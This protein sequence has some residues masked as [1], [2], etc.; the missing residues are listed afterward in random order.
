MMQTLARKTARIPIAESRKSL[1]FFSLKFS[2]L[3]DKNIYHPLRLLFPTNREEDF[4]TNLRNGRNP[5]SDDEI[6][7]E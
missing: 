6:P 1:M 7:F 4:T 3:H 5:D 2:L